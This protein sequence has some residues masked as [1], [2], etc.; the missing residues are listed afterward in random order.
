L[1]NLKESA[2]IFRQIRGIIKKNPPCLGILHG[3]RICD[4]L[5]SI[6]IIG[7]FLGIGKIFKEHI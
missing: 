1:R 6:V 2:R 4:M 7:I 5:L 3:L